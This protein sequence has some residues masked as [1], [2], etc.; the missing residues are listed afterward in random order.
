MYL[1]AVCDAIMNIAVLMKDGQTLL[2]KK[3]YDAAEA[4]FQKVITL[5]NEE[6]NYPER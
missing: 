4:V 2:G 5:L 1:W 6:K 3:Q